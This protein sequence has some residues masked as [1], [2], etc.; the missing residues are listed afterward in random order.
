VVGRAETLAEESFQM[1][2]L[3]YPQYTRPRLWQGR[4]VPEALLSGDHARI[5]AWRRAAAESLTRRRRPDLWERGRCRG[6][7]ANQ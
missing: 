6:Q 7:E 2:L 4:A 3:E 5:R 1:G